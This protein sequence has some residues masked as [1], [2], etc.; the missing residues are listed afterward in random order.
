MYASNT[1]WR[2]GES[3]GRLAY[4]RVTFYRDSGYILGCAADVLGTTFAIVSGDLWGKGV[5]WLSL[6]LHLASETDHLR[7]RA[8]E[9]DER[10]R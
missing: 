4:L 1:R 5:S 7:G 2:V 8:D 3:S 10:M 6:R 9:D